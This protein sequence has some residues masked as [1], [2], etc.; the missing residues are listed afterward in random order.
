MDIQQ[1]RDEFY[2]LYHEHITRPG[3]DELLKFLEEKSDFFTAP[4]STRFHLACEGG[5]LIHSINVAHEMMKYDDE[6]MESLVICGLLHDVCKVNFY[7]LSLRNSKNEKTGQWE[8]VPFYQVEDRFPYGHGEKSVFM[9]ER[10]M[11]LKTPEAV[12]IR[13]HMGGFD[14]A[15]KGGFFSISR[16]YEMYPLAVKLHLADTAASYLVEAR[17]A[18]PPQQQ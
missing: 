7:K 5:L 1:Y 15:V 13:W 12:A 14:D 16:A 18:Q 8:K 3:A 11:R 6:P 17:G 4:A 9:I 2:S 10:F